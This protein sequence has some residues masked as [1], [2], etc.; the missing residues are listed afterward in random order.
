MRKLISIFMCLI[1]VFSMIGACSAAVIGKTSYG[2]VEKQTYGNPSST[3]T[4]AI[5]VGV[6]PREHGFHDA[7]VSALKTQTASSNKKYLLYR[8]HV[9]KTPMNYYK[10][11]MYGQLLGNKF[12]V[13]DVKRS[14]PNVVFDIHEDAW[15]SSGYK[16]PRFLDPVSKTAKTYNYINRVKA[17]MSF[18]KVYV[19]PSGTSPKYVTKPIASKGIPTIIYETYKYDSYSKKVADANLFIKTLNN[20]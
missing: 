2:W 14:H 1:F 11:R 13:P 18:L 4:I 16:Y 6:H 3:N 15:K 9:T 8:I 7:M 5:I 17:K 20:L 10:G 19:P 12:V